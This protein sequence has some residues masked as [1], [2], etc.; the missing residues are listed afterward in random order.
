MTTH[1][2]LVLL[3]RHLACKENSPFSLIVDS[4]AQLGSPLLKE[5]AH[6]SLA[7][8]TFLAFETASKP[9]YASSFFD[10]TNATLLQIHSFARE[11]AGSA[12]PLTKALVIIDSLN[13]LPATDL[14][15][16]ISGLVLPST[17]VVACFHKDAPSPLSPG[18]PNS[19]SLLKYIS[20]SVLEVEPA[21][22]E[23]SEELE[24]KL[25]LFQFPVNQGLNLTK[26]KLYMTCRRKSGKAVNYEFLVDCESHAY[27]VY[28]SDKE[29]ELVDDEAL[30]KGLTTF[31]LTSNSK[32]KLARELVDLPFMEA[33]T[34][35]GKFGGAIVYEFEKDDDYDEEDPYEDPF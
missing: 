24:S 31:N 11:N 15:A 6:K 10:C 5:Y 18:Y 33:Q 30:L 4:L 28:K 13:Y 26:F 29:E 23:D 22:I 20:Q 32:Q 14:A 8:V 34:E 19:L 9:A 2:S 25:A 12:A 27:D 7:P 35:L 17:S 1:P 16:L 21:K 3:N